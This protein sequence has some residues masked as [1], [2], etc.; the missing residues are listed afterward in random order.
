[1]KHWNIKLFLTK[2]LSHSEHIIIIIIAYYHNY[3]YYH[4]YHHYHCF[5]NSILSSL[6]EQAKKLGIQL[7]LK[8]CHNKINMIRL[9]AFTNTTV[10]QL[11]F[12]YIFGK[13]R[14]RNS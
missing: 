13:K 14:Y 2:S 10:P 8:N 11:V 7:L 1:M 5:Y 9:Q 4:Y 3:N 6:T 12:H